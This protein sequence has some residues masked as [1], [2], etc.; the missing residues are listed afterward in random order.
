MSK[1]DDQ[2]IPDLIYDS[3]S[4]IQYKKGRFFGKVNVTIFFLIFFTGSM[5]CARHHKFKYRPK[6]SQ[7]D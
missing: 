6:Y 1:E 5:Y 4:R 3:H 7:I 2:V